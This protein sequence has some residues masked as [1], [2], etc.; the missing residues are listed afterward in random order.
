MEMC[1]YITTIYQRQ[2]NIFT[3]TTTTKMK[4]KNLYV[5]FMLYFKIDSRRGEKIQRL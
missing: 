3:T 5:L 1:F 2:L 4:E